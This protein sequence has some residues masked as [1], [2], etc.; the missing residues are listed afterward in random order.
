M[1]KYALVV[2]ISSYSDPE[3]SD[4]SFAARD[5]QEVGRCLADVCGF[6]DVRTLASGGQREPDHTYIVDVL[7]NLAP[8]LSPVDL[9]LF[10]FAGH[11]IETKTGAHLLTSNSRI[12]MPE[13]ASISMRV[14]SDCLSGIGCAN[15]VLILDACRN[16]PRKG[17][18]DEENLLT[19]GFSRDIMAVA[20]T[21]VEGVVPVTCVLFSCSLGERAYEWPDMGHGAFTYYLLEGL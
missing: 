17:M 16:D 1:K 15:R 7:D 14:L 18:G 21:A 4:L 5:A 11:G 10:Y 8:V 12:R 20:E 19:S 6:D 2:G 3:I 9:F 13:L